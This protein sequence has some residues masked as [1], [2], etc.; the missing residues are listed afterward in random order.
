[1][2]V[3]PS[4][5]PW[6]KKRARAPSSFLR[7][8]SFECR[9]PMKPILGVAFSDNVWTMATPWTHIARMS[10]AWFFSLVV[11]SKSWWF[12][13]SF[14]R[15]AVKVSTFFH[16]FDFADTFNCLV[17]LHQL[18]DT[19]TPDPSLSWDFVSAQRRYI[20]QIVFGCLDT[21]KYNNNNIAF[22]PKQVGV[23]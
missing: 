7:S 18:R 19:S 20:H 1:M 9:W 17:I 21:S 5:I 16:H 15:C 8:V 6:R 4:S 12:F 22:C 11:L 10:N 13:V 2:V 3:R 14:Q 23:G